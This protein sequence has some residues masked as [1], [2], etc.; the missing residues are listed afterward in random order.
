M[1]DSTNTVESSSTSSSS[2]SQSS[3]NQGGGSSHSVDVWVSKALACEHLSEEELRS[4]CEYVKNILVEESNVQP[5]ASPVRE[6]REK[7]IYII[8]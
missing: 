6:K 3:R 5:V 8:I 2:S 4:L 7:H 1:R